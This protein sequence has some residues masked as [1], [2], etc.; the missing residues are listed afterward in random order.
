MK[1]HYNQ[2]AET[3]K[4]T[5]PLG[6][7]VHLATGVANGVL[8]VRNLDDCVTLIRR[9]LTQSMEFDIDIEQRLTGE[10]IVLREQISRCVFRVTTGDRILAN[11]FWNFYL[12]AD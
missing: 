8:V 6:I 7:Q 9:I 12:A 5:H 1:E 2:R 4:E 11:S 10:Y 3:L